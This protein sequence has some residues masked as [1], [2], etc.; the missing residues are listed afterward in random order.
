MGAT[1]LGC[2]LPAA[3]GT[4]GATPLRPA[5]TLDC[6]VGTGYCISWA[7]GV[8]GH[9]GNPDGVLYCC[10]VGACTCATIVGAAIG[11]LTLPCELISSSLTIFI[12]RCPLIC[13]NVPK[14]LYHNSI[15]FT[16]SPLTP[17]LRP[18]LHA[19]LAG[20]LSTTTSSRRAS[21]HWF[22]KI[23]SSDPVSCTSSVFS[24]FSRVCH[25]CTLCSPWRT[26]A[27]CALVARPMFPESSSHIAHTVLSS[28]L[29]TL[30]K[31]LKPV[32]VYSR[33][34]HGSM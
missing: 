26:I 1:A 7:M 16:A 19:Q 32:V 31:A 14:V 17:P 4:V 9:G 25:R 10:R 33:G 27:S 13:H 15:C 3:T 5:K 30:P 21:V 8:C 23:L 24:A 28:S 20:R 2:T 22:L 6:F 34:L 12:V 29:G 18:M 11:A